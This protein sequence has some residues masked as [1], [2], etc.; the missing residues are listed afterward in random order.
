[1]CGISGFIST[2]TFPQARESIE[3]MVDRQQH[4]GPDANGIFESEEDRVFMGHNRLSILD[5]SENANQPFYSEDGRYV[6]VYNGEVYNYQQLARELKDFHPRTN[7]DT[8]VVLECFAQM[9]VG[10]LFRFNGMFAFAIWDSKV[11]E[12]FVARDRIGIKPLYYFYDRYLFAFASELKGLEACSVIENPLKI[13]QEAFL[14]YLHLGFISHPLSIYENVFKLPAGSY[15]KIDLNSSPEVTSYWDSPALVSSSPVSDPKVAKRELHG[16]LQQSVKDR[17][18]SD[19]PLGTSLSG[20]IDS[21]LVSALAAGLVNQPLKTFNIGF[22]ESKFNESEYA[23]KVASHLKTDHQTWILTEADAIPMLEQVLSTFDEPFA[24]TSAIPTM[25]V[26]KL[27]R[28]KVKVILTGDGG[29]ELFLGYG[30]YAWASRLEKIKSGHIKDIA[31]LLLNSTGNSRLQRAS[32]LFRSPGLNGLRNH[33]FSQ[34]QYYF[35]NTEINQLV[36][37]EYLGKLFSYQDPGTPRSLSP[38]ESQSLFDLEYYL[39]DDLLTKVDRASMKYSLECRVPLLDHR[40][41]SYALNLDLALKKKGNVTK[42]LLKEILFDMVPKKLFDRPKRGFAIPLDSWLNKDLSF[43]FDDYLNRDLIADLGFFRIEE[44]SKLVK[45]Y[46]AGQHYL[47]NR[48]WLMMLWHKWI[49]EKRAIIDL[50]PPHNK[51]AR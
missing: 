18:I 12:L 16:L 33:I 6:M 44:V 4:R 47:Y 39:A 45:R 43:L 19:V 30:A 8:E 10:C 22:K 51:K 13:S 23:Q 31:A 25:L 5:L 3:A 32:N 49:I 7:C 34:E 21:S 11:K 26:S 38:P 48:L 20:G 9:G 1:M 28:E 2:K 37:P 42:T 15:A 29:D 41:V 24:D 17:L 35:S 46:R 14:T 50:K 36:K 27:A 40:V